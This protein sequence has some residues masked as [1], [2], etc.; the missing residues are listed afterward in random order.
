MKL[1]QAINIDDLRRMAKRKLPRMIFDYI[2]GG[3][4]DEVTLSRAVTRYN[5]YEL[6][7]RALRDVTGIDTSTTI[8]G[9]ETG[10]PFF[11]SPTASTRLFHPAAGEL[12]MA[13]AAEKA[14]V[15][16]ACSTLASQTVEDIAKATSGPKWVQLYVWTDKEIVKGFLE[17]AKEAGFTGCI[18]TVDLPVAGNRE[19]DP[20]NHFAVPPSPNLKVASQVLAR[21]GW[22]W[23]LIRSPKITPA[24]FTHIQEKGDQGGVIG[25]VNRQFSRAVTWSDVEWMRE[26]WGP[27]FAIKGISRAEDAK[28]AIEIG[29]DAVW[30]SNHGGRQ[31]D[32]SVP[33][34]DLLPEIVEAVR[35]RADIIADGGVRR[36]SHIAKLLMAGATG[37]ALGRAALYGLG[38]G[39]EAGVSRALTILEE[40]FL[41]TMALMGATKISELDPDLMRAPKI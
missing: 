16:Y 30:V 13:R 1:D 36:G 27:G 25:F 10:R 32:T 15:I 3:A 12:A 28:R 19:R 8:M 23:D 22:L 35:G 33:T 2:D 39:G 40:E 34:I 7:W 17:R 20:R 14:G 41:R 9:Q 38:A 11:I 37:V 21:P 18:L 26:F 24:N 29:A 31:L 5:D 6:T 4:D